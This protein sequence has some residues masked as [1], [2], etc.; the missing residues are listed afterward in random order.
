M[1]LMPF[2]PKQRT[3][4]YSRLIPC[5][6]TFYDYSTDDILYMLIKFYQLLSTSQRQA[7]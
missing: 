1:S 4:G 2:Q 5:M 3:E 7:E 6:E